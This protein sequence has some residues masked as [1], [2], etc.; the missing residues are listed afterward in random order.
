MD[1]QSVA[2]E[3]DG[4][5]HEGMLL[6]SSDSEEDMNIDLSTYRSTTTHP[7]DTLCCIKCRLIILVWDSH[8]IWISSSYFLHVIG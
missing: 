8:Q 5:E 1:E 7:D 2:G 6:S 3:D 4:D